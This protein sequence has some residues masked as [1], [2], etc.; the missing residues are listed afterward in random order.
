MKNSNVRQSITYPLVSSVTGARYIPTVSTPLG[1]GTVSLST[2]EKTLKRASEDMRQIL[3]KWRDMGGKP[4]GSATVDEIRKLPTLIDAMKARLRDQGRNPNPFA[5]ELDV[6]ITDTTYPTEGRQLDARIYAPKPRLNP[7]GG[8][9]PVI[10][11]YHGG[12]W[13]LGSILSGE[14]SA[15][16]LAVRCQAIVVSIDYGSAPENRFP[17]QHE[18]AFNA[19][20]WVLQNAESWGGD[21]E[22]IALAGESA[23]GNLAINTAIMARDMAVP[24][25]KY[26]LLIHPVTGTD[27]NTPSYK[28]NAIAMPLNR[29]AMDWCFNNVFSSDQDALSPLIDVLGRADLHNLPPATIITADID[30]LMSEGRMLAN[31]MREAGTTVNYKNYMGVT[32]EFF[33]L[34]A[35]IAPALRA[36]GTAA[37][38][39]R[40][41]FSKALRDR[42]VS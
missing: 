4:Q 21:P 24:R 15:L 26:M 28:K 18:A 14:T 5:E 7:G 35:A 6:R 32:H 23:G 10:V 36:Q 30:P 37:H 11:Y 41:A 3:I 8:N 33:G 27:M 20:T 16:A 2:E 13:V 9:L 29:R 1:I 17:S 31:R 22:R 42:S 12:V 40:Q 39:I 38:D 25:P 19:Y 34:A